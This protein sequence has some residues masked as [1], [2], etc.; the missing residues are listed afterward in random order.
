MADVEKII[1]LSAL[2]HYNDKINSVIDEKVGTGGLTIDDTLSDTSTNPVQ[3]KA[4]KA[5]LDKKADKTDIPTSLPANGGDADTV[6]GKSSSDFSPFQAYAPIYAGDIKDISNMGTYSCYKGNC[7]NLPDIYMWAYVTMMQFHDVG[8]KTFL[9]IEFNAQST[10]QHCNNIYIAREYDVDSNGNM[11]WYRAC[12]GGIAETI[13]DWGVQ[14]VSDA[15]NAPYGFS[16]TSPDSANKPDTFWT[17]ILTVG[18]GTNGYKQQFAFPWGASRVARYRVQDN[19]NWGSWVNIADGGNADTVDGKHASD[20][21][22]IVS[23]EI[24]GTLKVSNAYPYNFQ[25]IPWGDG[26]HLRCTNSTNGKYTDIM[27]D[28]GHLYMLLSDSQTTLREVS[29]TPVKSITITNKILTNGTTYLFSS[30]QIE[31][32]KF[33]NRKILGIKC[34]ST[35]LRLYTPELFRNEEWQIRFYYYNDISKALAYDTNVSYTVYYV[36]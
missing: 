22:P 26:A 9:C 35:N 13:S 33:D 4:V 16:N 3:N 10:T 8:Y 5:E 2:N 36:D 6:G 29:T 20:F 18:G 25:I 12:D 31:S 15:N 7:T 32:R 21:A 30:N 24:Q 28:D 17:T 11:I 14:T 27:M 23:P 19:G 1:G 34:E